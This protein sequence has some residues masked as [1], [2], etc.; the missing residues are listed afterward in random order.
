MKTN[1]K[2]KNIPEGWKVKKLGTLVDIVSGGTPSTVVPEYWN[3]GINWITPSEIISL[4]KY[5]HNEQVTNK[6]IS[7]LGLRNSSATIIPKNSLILCSR[8]TIAEC[9]IN[10]KEVATNQGFKNLIPKEGIT[11]DYL[12]FWTKKNT[13]EY[14][15]I[16]QGSTF[17]EFSKKDVIKMEII[18][19]SLPE[20][21]RIVSVLET[22]D[23]GIEKLRQKITIKK[24]IKKG[25]MQELLIGEKLLPGFS[26][27]WQE[28][29]LGDIIEYKN[30]GSFEKLVTD[31]G[32]YFLI[33]LNSIDI[34]G[35]IKN[36]HKRVDGADWY[37]KKNDLIMVLSDIAHGYFLGLVDKIPESNKY[38]L[39]QRMGMLRKK[40]DFIDIEF[41]RRFLNIKR[42]YFKMHGQGS[43][44][45]NLSKG[46]I[47]K[48]KIML[49]ALEEQK[50]IALILT[51]SDEELTILEKKLV[52]WLEQK[53]YLLNNLVTGQ[54]RTPENL[55]ETINPK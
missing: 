19:P 17:L 26:D 23:S 36:K 51:T 18:L 1:K 40:V 2:Q 29:K 27:K 34:D 3:K 28:K 20:Q 7:E 49:P 15:R 13:K 42:T 8:A 43:S 30:G 38:V 53:K 14:F 50:A 12:Y 35:K 21:N 32:K 48:F 4:G 11:I 25:L 44:Q 52:F 47:L 46:D 41:V 31:N 45:Q 10:K 24:E 9:L 37:L 54:I 55:L 5:F 6:T 33:T 39:N 16:S 22:W